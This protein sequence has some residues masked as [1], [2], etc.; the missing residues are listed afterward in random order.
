MAMISRNRQQWTSAEDKKLIEL[1]KQ[2]KNYA[3]IATE[4]GRTED[5]VKARF[6]KI[7]VV[8]NYYP[9]RP[10]EKQGRK[11]CR[12]YDMNLDDLFRYLKYAGLKINNNCD[13]DSED[14]EDSEDSSDDFE[15]DQDSEESDGSSD[16][17][18]CDEDYD[19]VFDIVY[20]LKIISRKISIIGTAFI[21][22]TG[23]KTLTHLLSKY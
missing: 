13:H 4:L 14:S 18:E 2:N 16:G 9:G 19:G 8:K 20:N 1:Y 23:Y 11:I 3:Q 12:K 5:A 17:F 7:E 22:Y 6:V 10:F 15:S 21:L